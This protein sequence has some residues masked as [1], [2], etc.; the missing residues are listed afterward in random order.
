MTPLAIGST[1]AIASKQPQDVMGSSMMRVGVV[2]SHFATGS[3]LHERVDAFPLAESLIDDFA[4]LDRLVRTGGI[5]LVGGLAVEPVVRAA[6]SC[7]L[8]CDDADVRRSEA[9]AQRARIEGGLVFVGHALDTGISDR[10][11]L[12]GRC[13]E[14][15]D[16][17]LIGEDLDLDL[18]EHRPEVLVVLGMEYGAYVCK[19]EAFFHSAFSD[20]NPRDIP[21]ADVHDALGIVDQVVDLTLENGLEVGLHLTAGN[22]DEDTQRHPGTGFNVFEVLPDNL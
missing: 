5:D 6:E 19:A 16:F 15:I 10:V 21:L 22:L 14:L 2:L 8:G 7:P 20:T 13:E 18:V 17:F 4:F 11:C 12:P 9:L 3:L 1:A